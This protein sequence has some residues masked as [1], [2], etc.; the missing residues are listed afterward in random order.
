MNSIV[1]LRHRTPTPPEDER[2]IVAAWL[3]EATG[4]DPAAL[5]RLAAGPSR[6]LGELV[7]DVNPACESVV[8]EALE[9]ASR[10]GRR[11]GEALVEKGVLTPGERDSLVEFQRHQRG[12][13]PTEDRLRLGQILVTLGHISESNLAEALEGQRTSKRPLGEELVAR[14]RI[15]DD[16]LQS[17]LGT[18]RRLVVAALVAALAM[19]SPGTMAP[20]EAAQSG[21]HSINVAVRVLPFVRIKVLRQPESMEIT[22]EDAERGYVEIRSASHLHVTANT[23]WE[24]YFKPRGEVALSARVSGLE[25]DVVVG[26]AGG[27]FAGLRPQSNSKDFDLSYR[28]DLAPGVGPGTYPWPL[29]ISVQGA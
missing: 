2:G 22:K 11:V 5:H 29:T 21:T 19:A 6:R 26:P 14:G 3:P 24:V 23:P 28:F 1:P 18:Q 8:A 9:N 12:E 20:A 25:G 27:R 15:S 10:T 13:A 7:T 4:T 17:A 16:V